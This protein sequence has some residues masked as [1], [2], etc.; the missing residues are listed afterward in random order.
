MIH[1]VP[2][3]QKIGAF[4]DVFFLVVCIFALCSFASQKTRCL[5]S[6]LMGVSMKRRVKDLLLINLVYCC[7]CCCHDRSIHALPTMQPWEDFR[8][9][10]REQQSAAISMNKPY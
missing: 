4:I 10:P 6:Y 7:C 8:R 9:T 1:Y 5:F 2:S 3:A